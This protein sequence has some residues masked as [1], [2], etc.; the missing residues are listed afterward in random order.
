MGWDSMKGTL[1]EVIA[2]KLEPWEYDDG[3]VSIA[4]DHQCE[5]SGAGKWTLW[6][7]RVRAGVRSIFCVVM[8][9]DGE[10]MACK[11]MATEESPYY[12]DC[13]QRMLDAV[14]SSE[15]GDAAWRAKLGVRS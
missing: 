12:Y 6:V 10:W 1:Q 14:P 8:Q 5:P 15:A 3:S 2:D 4:T 7:V 13:P 9:R 11:T